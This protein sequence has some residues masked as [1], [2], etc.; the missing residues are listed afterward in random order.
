M[1]GF[2]FHGFD[3][4]FSFLLILSVFFFIFY[5]LNE[6]SNKKRSSAK[7]ILGHRYA[8][9]EIDTYKY[10]TRLNEIQSSERKK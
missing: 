7:E 5:L 8:N 1:N 4:G 6:K 9:R 10:H 2:G 3:M